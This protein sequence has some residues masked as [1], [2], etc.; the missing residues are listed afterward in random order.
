MLL[1]RLEYL[2]LTGLS[3]YQLNNRSSAGYIVSTPRHGHYDHLDLAA[4]ELINEQTKLLISRTWAAAIARYYPEVWYLA[5]AKAEWLPDERSLFVVIDLRSQPGHP[6]SGF[7]ATQG[8]PD[9]ITT[10]LSRAFNLGLAAAYFIDIKDVIDPIRRR[11]VRLQIELPDKFTLSPA[12]PG[13]KQTVSDIK[14]RYRD[15]YKQARGHLRGPP[16]RR[17]KNL[18]RSIPGGI[19]GDAA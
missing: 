16:P 13:F 8:T 14:R 6:G 1:T 15:L 18:L 5:L 2:A 7:I 4:N 19:D 11:S 17:P 3:P 10:K 9:E 12:D